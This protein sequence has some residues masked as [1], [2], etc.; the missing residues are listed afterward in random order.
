[1]KHVL[2]LF[3]VLLWCVSCVKEL[4][5]SIEE[6]E[7]T[8]VNCLLTNDTIQRLSLTKSAKIGGSYLF[9]EVRDAKI[10]LSAGDSAIG[11]FER[12]G[13]DNWQLRYTPSIETN[14]T[15]TVQLSD[16]QVLWAT[17]SMPTP[18][19]IIDVRAK[20]AYPS[21]FF[22]QYQAD[23]ANWIYVLGCGSSLPDNITRPSGSEKLHILIG[24]DYPAIDR[25][26]EEGD[27]TDLVQEATT[28]AYRYY[29]RIPPVS[30]TLKNAI[31]FCVQTN[32]EEYSFIV[33]RTA[34]SEY[35]QYLKTSLQKMFVYISEDDPSIGFDEGRIYSN[36]Q[37][38]IGI[39]AACYDRYFFYVN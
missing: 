26:N 4:P 13:Y 7:H 36:I 10:T 38:G 37:N 11:T 28:P 31:P 14:Y 17:T 3:L 9:R 30:D 1:M 12:K 16:G 22:E 5:V 20:N 27:M 32:Y 33:V 2:L 35:D 23:H 24:T 15:L 29:L 39:F 19:W 6:A 18:D 8:V 21:K 25:F 34:S